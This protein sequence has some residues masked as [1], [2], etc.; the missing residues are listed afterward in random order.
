MR[1]ARVDELAVWDSDQ[2][3]NVSTIYDSGNV[4][5]LDTLTTKP[6]HWWRMGD[7]DNYPNIQDHGTQANCVFVMYNMTAADIVSDVP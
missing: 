1:Q 2:S 5:D 3:A 6:R 4:K 7:G